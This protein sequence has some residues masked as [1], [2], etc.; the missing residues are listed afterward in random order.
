MISHSRSQRWG[1]A[2]LVNLLLLCQS[3]ADEDTSGKVLE[4]TG[5][6]LV[7]TMREIADPSTWVR[8]QLLK[9]I[10]DT[11]TC[12]L[13]LPPPPPSPQVLLEF[14]AHWCPACQ[15]FQPSYLEVGQF[16]KKR[17]DVIPRVVVARLDCA[18]YVR[19]GEGECTF[20]RFHLHACMLGHAFT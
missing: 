14:F 13:P 10:L 12:H 5:A 8:L 1:L 19:Q 20:V 2:L 7:P 17:G 16:F 6:S 4:L 3:H 15:K 18:N 9:L 11:L